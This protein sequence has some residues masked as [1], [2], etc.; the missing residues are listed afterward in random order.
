MTLQKATSVDQYLVPA[1][2]STAEIKIKGSRFIAAIRY[3]AD[4]EAAETT[5]ESF[6]KK[7]YNATHNCFAYRIDAHT[8]RYSDDGEP[9]GTA[10]KPIM[11]ILDSS[12][13]LHILCVV[14]R[15][16][17]GTKLGTGGLIRAY[18]EAVEHAL[19]P[20]KTKTIVRMQGL[21]L[22]FTYDHENLVRKIFMDFSG[23]IINSNYSD[24]IH[25]DVAIPRSMHPEFTELLIEKSNSQVTIHKQ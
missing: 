20:L 7:Y 5:L 12:E 16:F 15:Y 10:G 23:K 22:A 4:K 25:M 9:S 3:V 1:S 17:G 2:E 6:R 13:I 18:S 11:Q 14:T 8:F 19:E 24:T 21:Q